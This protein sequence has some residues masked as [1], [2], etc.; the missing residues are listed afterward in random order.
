ML[1][2]LLCIVCLKNVNTIYYK[3]STVSRRLLRCGGPGSI[4][5]DICSGQSGIG[6]LFF[7]VLRVFSRL[8]VLFR[9]CS[10]LAHIYDPKNFAI[11]SVLR[12]HASAGT[13]M[14]FGHSAEGTIVSEE[15]AVVGGRRKRGDEEF[16]NLLSL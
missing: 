12:E 11:G 8:P 5:G 1:G 3:V 15:K 4:P 2:S 14:L 9:R 13:L 6:T 10:T 7:R 16:H